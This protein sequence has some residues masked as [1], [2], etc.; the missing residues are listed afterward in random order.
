MTFFSLEAQTC[1]KIDLQLNPGPL[2][3]M[4]QNNNGVLPLQPTV[5]G[6][7]LQRISL[8]ATPTDSH[9]FFHSVHMSMFNY[10]KN[11]ILLERLLDIIK[12]E[13]TVHWLN[14]VPFFTSSLANFDTLTENYFSREMYNN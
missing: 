14:Y 1:N 5:N 13:L 3:L 8:P 2:T 4:L 7:L 10:L 11:K 9:C 6:D 12:N